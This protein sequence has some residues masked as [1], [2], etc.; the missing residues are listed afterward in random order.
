MGDLSEIKGTSRGGFVRQLSNMAASV[1]CGY[2]VGGGGIGLLCVPSFLTCHE[3]VSLSLS[4]L[5]FFLFFILVALGFE[6]RAYMLSHSTSP[7]L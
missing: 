1:L 5:S 3:L 7:F 6:L 4:F 2:L